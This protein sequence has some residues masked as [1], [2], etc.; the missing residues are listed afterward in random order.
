MFLLACP[1]ACQLL[2]FF[3]GLIV[4]SGG[5]IILIADRKESSLYVPE[6]TTVSLVTDQIWEVRVKLTLSRQ[7]VIIVLICLLFGKLVFFLTSVACLRCETVATLDSLSLL[8]AESS[9]RWRQP[10]WSAPGQHA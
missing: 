9:S 2:H 8:F 4:Y 1:A 6:L 5:V 10:C 7:P 3:I